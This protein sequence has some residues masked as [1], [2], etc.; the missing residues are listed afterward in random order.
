MKR[1]DL[2][3]HLVAHGAHQAR[4]GA[5]H[6]IWQRGTTKTSVPRHREIAPLLARKICDQL[7]VPAPPTR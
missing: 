3:R 1:A 2:I 7:G 4:E 6:S 5:R